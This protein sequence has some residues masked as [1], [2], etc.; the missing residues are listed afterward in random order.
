MNVRSA[1]V[2]A[3]AALYVALAG[4]IRQRSVQ[5]AAALWVLGSAAVF[6][7]AG[8][9]L[10]FVRGHEVL[11]VATEVV[12]GQL[13]LLLA[14]VLIV[15]TLAMTR[16]RP[17]VDLAARAPER[18]VARRET[19]RLVGY[20]VLAGLGGLAVG[21]LAGDHAYGLH[22][23]GTIY[24]L[25]DGTLQAGWVAGWAAY[26]F[27]F[28][29]VVPYVVFRR[30]GYDDTRLNL[31]SA[32]RRRDAALILVIL[33]VESAAE[34][35]TVSSEIFALD[36]GQLLVGLP[37]AFTVNFVGTVLPI[38][39]FVYAILLP[40]FAR[41]TGSPATTAVLGASHTR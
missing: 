32:D 27:L 41:L 9:E 21:E 7:L 30:R 26:N 8:G 37:L 15:I 17:R 11:P 5:V 4:L 25:H 13:N 22:L 29:A 34:L 31:R 18:S 2:L 33:L 10:P 28:F 1:L 12:N 6:P 36:A 14:L 3:L 39:V 24:G 23:P 16:R 38:M 19:L 40:R 35:G 20:G